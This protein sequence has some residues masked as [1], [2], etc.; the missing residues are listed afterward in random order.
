MSHTADLPAPSTPCRKDLVDALLSVP[1][2]GRSLAYWLMPVPAWDNIL[3]NP[4]LKSNWNNAGGNR[5]FDL[6]VVLAN[7][8]DHVQLIVTRA[9]Y[10]HRVI[11]CPCTEA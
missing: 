7:A 3:H 9:G 6:H 8:C 10:P 11:D 1:E 4:E 5:L 2:T